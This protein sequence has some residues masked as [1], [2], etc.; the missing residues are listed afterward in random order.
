MKRILL[1]AA[2]AALALNSTVIWAESS[3]AGSN[4]GNVRGGDFA[5][6]HDIIGKKCTPCHSS[7]K[8]D[9]ALKS[10][11]DMRAIQK[12]MEKQGAQLTAGE[13]EVLG[14]YWTQNPLKK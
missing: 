2:L 5:Q 8:I 4:L 3:S 9:A 13:R 6:A 12:R 1:P 7:A 10:G 11:K 14:I